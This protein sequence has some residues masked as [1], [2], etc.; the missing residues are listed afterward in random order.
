MDKSTMDKCN[1]TAVDSLPF[2]TDVL[3]K[4]EAKTKKGKKPQ[5]WDTRKQYTVQVGDILSTGKAHH[6][7]LAVRLEGCA[8]LLNFGW[9]KTLE[10][11]VHELKLIH[12]HFCRVRTCPVCQWR[13]QQMLL[14]RF[15][16]ALPLIRTDYPTTRYI[17]LTLTVKN[18]PVDELR[19]TIQH[20]SK[21]WHNLTK[22]KAFPAI[23]FVRMLEI[24]KET[25]TYDKKTK[26]IIRQARTNYAHPHFHI[27]LALPPSYFSRG[28]LSTAAWAAL[29]KHALKADYT[30]VCDVRIVKIKKTDVSDSSGDL[31]GIKA[32]IVETI[33]YTVKPADMVQDA[34]FLL[35]LVDQLH[36]IRAMSLGGIFKGYLKETDEDEEE[37]EGGEEEEPEEPTQGMRF[38]WIS[39]VKRYQL[40][41]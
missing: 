40:K 36:N 30:P 33:K 22:R 29:W 38:G 31:D 18:C 3:P 11:G 27:I 12:A 32:A 24:T 34:G 7:K 20:M 39:P 23:G 21:A 15:F 19:A 6:K 8:N 1:T 17:F 41:P 5:N 35:I 14:H 16:K 9:V 10:L 26:K 25:D 28:Y 13:R 4:E 37:P 2:L